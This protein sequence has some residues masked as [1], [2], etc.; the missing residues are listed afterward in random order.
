MDYLYQQYVIQQSQESK[1]KEKVEAFLERIEPFSKLS[2]L[3]EAKDMAKR[4]LPTKPEVTG[5]YVG[6]IKCTVV[7][8]EK[9]FRIS[10]DS[11]EYFICYSFHSL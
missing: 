6:N 9:E 11:K 10:V 1:D 8:R 7:N 5:F 2:T 3:E 4:I